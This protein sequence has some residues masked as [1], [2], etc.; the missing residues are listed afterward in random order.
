VTLLPGEIAADGRIPE[1]AD[2]RKADPGRLRAACEAWAE[3]YPE[4]SE[5]GAAAALLGSRARLRGQMPPA[6]G[7]SSIGGNSI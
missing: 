6:S 7:H 2:K 5:A 3:F 1:T 4:V